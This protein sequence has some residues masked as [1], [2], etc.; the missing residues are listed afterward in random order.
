MFKLHSSFPD[1]LYG[2]QFCSFG[3]KRSYNATE[4]CISEE[5]AT[6]SCN[7]KEEATESCISEKEAIAS[8]SAKDTS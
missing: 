2:K 5:E 8:Y 3:T 1:K 6:E 4:S 7:N